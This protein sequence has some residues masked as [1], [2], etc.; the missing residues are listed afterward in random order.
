MGTIRKQLNKW[1]KEWLEEDIYGKWTYVESYIYRNWP[2]RVT[3]NLPERTSAR[4]FVYSA[5][6]TLLSED[7]ENGRGKIRKTKEAWRSYNQNRIKKSSGSYTY[8]K[9]TKQDKK[10][11]Q[12]LAREAGLSSGADVVS[13]ILNGEYKEQAE[14]KRR[15]KEEKSRK[16][17]D[18]RYGASIL[19]IL[20]SNE[21]NEL[22]KSNE[23]L[24]NK[25]RETEI[26]LGSLAK[27]LSEHYVFWD[28]ILKGDFSDLT[29]LE[30]E[31]V[32]KLS[33]QIIETSDE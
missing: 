24:K 23:E 8:V 19:D 11:M 9:L 14:I 29:E 7:P 25:L 2:A 31:Q 26:K 5:F 18:Q 21:L 27:L 17:A 22:R 16:R 3:R 32:E 4:E 1:D 33:E 10:K 6:E 28:R 15:E 13:A 20:W 12:A 30:D